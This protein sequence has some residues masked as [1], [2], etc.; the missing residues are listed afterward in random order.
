MGAEKYG[1]GVCLAVKI[2][3]SRNHNSS[4]GCVLFHSRQGPFLV[5]VPCCFLAAAAVL[6]LSLKRP[7]YFGLDATEN[8]QT[9]VC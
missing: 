5:R 4:P 9:P 3:G 6:Q 7:C 8:G 1:C 2:T